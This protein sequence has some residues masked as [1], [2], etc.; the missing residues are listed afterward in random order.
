[1]LSAQ[2][3][4][5]LSMLFLFILGSLYILYA[6]QAYVLPECVTRLPTFV[7]VSFVRRFQFNIVK[8]SHLFFHCQWFCGLTCFSYFSKI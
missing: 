4:V 1:M 5:V 6:D 3:L 8:F 2:S 7:Q